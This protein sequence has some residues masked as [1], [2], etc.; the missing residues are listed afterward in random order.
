MPCKYLQGIFLP[1]N[2]AMKVLHI[3]ESLGRAGAEQ[4]LVNL[5]PELNARGVNSEVAVLWPPYDLQSALESRGVRVHRLHLDYARRWNLARGASRVRRLA[6]RGQYDILHSHLLFANFYTA[7]A[8]P[9]P[10]NP[11]RVATLHGLDFDFFNHSRG[12]RVIK[13]ILPLVLRCGFDACS[14]VSRPVAAHF[15]AHVPGLNPQ[16][17]PNAFPTS[18]APISNF[19]RATIRRAQGIPDDVPLIVTVGRLAAEKGHQHLFTALQI[20]E[21]REL[22][23][24]LLLLGDGPRR[25]ELADLA[26]QLGLSERVVFAGVLPHDAMMP[27]VQSADVFA[28]SSLQEGFG[29]APA[30]ALLLEIPTITTNVGGLKDLIENEVSG[31]LVP[32]AD[33][34]AMAAAIER[35]LGNKDLS[36][37]LGRGGR[38]RIAEEFGAPKIAEMWKQFY[39]ELI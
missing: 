12:G 18:L 6:R 21:K 25:A 24:H 35:V 11:R 33:A 20:L 8:R 28:L 37:R 26:T 3:I 31:L 34:E 30:E 9:V 15:A 17:I 32:P 29:L 16:W 7:A 1:P 5:L 19:D 2:F 4:V 10:K 23:P 14:A 39:Q 38:M 36:A 22:R 13:Q 27:L